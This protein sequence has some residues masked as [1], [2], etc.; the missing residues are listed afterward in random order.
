MWAAHAGLI[1]GRT[2]DVVLATNSYL[3]TIARSPTVVVVHDLFGFDRTYDLPAGAL[4]E[5]LTLPF[6][7]RRGAGF[8]C[9]SRA[10]E[11]ALEARFPPVRGRTRVIPHGVSAEFVNASPREV[12][13]RHDIE[14]RYV[15]AVG[16]L[17]PRK[18]LVR[19]VRAFAA[20]DPAVRG[21]C[22]LVLAGLRGWSIEDLDE[23]TG[24]SA[25]TVQML[26]FV[27][28]EDLPG[29]Y[30]EAT[31]FAYPSL[32]EGFGLPVLEAMAAGCPVLTSDRSSLPEVGGDA[33]VLVDPTDERAIARGL[34]R[35]LVDD[36]YRAELR[37]RGRDRAAHFTWEHTARETLGYLRSVT[38]TLAAGKSR[39]S[40]DSS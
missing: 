17:E 34:E 11:S 37:H 22:S 27:E 36:A 21:D 31:A 10:T 7:V 6:A 28:D 38:S 14:G 19:L 26:G 24:A 9:P 4:G 33:A 18:N 16:T 40:A 8:I 23:V 29:L 1:A 32:A 15:L 5:R 25:K 12:A 20:L 35:L 39:D 2:N 13:A 3:M 30:A